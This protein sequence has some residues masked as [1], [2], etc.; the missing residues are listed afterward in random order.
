MST[1]TEQHKALVTYCADHTCTTC[2]MH[3]PALG[4]ID[5][6]DYCVVSHALDKLEPLAVAEGAII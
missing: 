6:D 4:C 2:P 1:A 5:P 3:S